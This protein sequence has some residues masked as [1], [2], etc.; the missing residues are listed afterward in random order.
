MKHP[1]DLAK[2]LNELFPNEDLKKI[3]DFACCAFVVMEAGKL[4]VKVVP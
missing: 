1:Q 3:S 4:T 2:E